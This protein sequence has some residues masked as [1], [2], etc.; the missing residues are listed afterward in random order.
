[1]KWTCRL[2]VG[3]KCLH[4]FRGEASWKWLLPRLRRRNHYHEGNEIMVMMYW[5]GSLEVEIRKGNLLDR[6]RPE[7]H[8][9]TNMKLDL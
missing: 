8:W 3:G 4:N 1:M 5:A 9:K 2:Y 7:R 6:G